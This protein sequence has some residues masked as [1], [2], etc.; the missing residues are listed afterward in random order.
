MR[1]LARAVIL[2][3]IR[4]GGVD[5]N[6]LHDPSHALAHGPCL[7]R[8]RDLDAPVAVGYGLTLTDVFHAAGVALKFDMTIESCACCV[9]ERQ[10]ESIRRRALHLQPDFALTGRGHIQQDCTN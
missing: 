9:S 4:S 10:L 8:I 5:A 2:V 7:R 1:S 3:V 6:G